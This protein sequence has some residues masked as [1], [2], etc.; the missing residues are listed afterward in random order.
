M[1]STPVLEG[2]G[3]RL[4]PLAIEHLPAL[5]RTHDKS[6]WVW[7]SE[8]GGTPE[9]MQ[10]LVERAL[11]AS[12]AGTTQI[13]TATLLRAAEP[14]LVA[15]SSRL[16]DLDAHHCRCELGWTWI[17]PALRG[18]GL[19]A[20]MK[21]LQ[22]AHA[23]DTLGMRRVALK[24]HHSNIRSQRA[25]LKLGAHFEGVHRR[26][27]IMPDGTSRDTHW[28]SIIDADW[29]AVR[30]HLLRRIDNEPLPVAVGGLLP[31]LPS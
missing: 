5:D 30:A 15:G 22:L 6:T 14:P 18:S 21:L 2:F 7:M 20:R 24:T 23:F 31:P 17:A 26:H 29:P 11:Q 28:F 3:V 12:A 8:S 1:T 10:A 13:W 27:M 25:M 4:I 16:A 19:N 9:L